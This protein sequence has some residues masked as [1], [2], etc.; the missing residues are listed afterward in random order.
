MFNAVHNL[1]NL[2]S[3]QKRHECEQCGVWRLNSISNRKNLMKLPGEIL[4]TSGFGLKF[5]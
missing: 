3:A 4:R 5:K 1:R 2:L